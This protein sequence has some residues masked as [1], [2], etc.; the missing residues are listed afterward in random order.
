MRWPSYRQIFVYSQPIDMRWG[1]ERLLHLVQDDMQHDINLGHLFLFLGR[2]RKRLKAL[3]FDGSGLVLITKRMEKKSFMHINDLSKATLT[4]QELQL[5]IHGSIL[6]S[7]SLP[8]LK[9]T[10]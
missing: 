10:K 3:A 6:R 4:R 1:F 7:Y 9:P 8:K 5:L 2:N